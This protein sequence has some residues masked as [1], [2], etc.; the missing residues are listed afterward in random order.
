[1]QGYEVTADDTRGNFLNNFAGQFFLSNVAWALS[2]W[3][4]VTNFDLD[5][6]DWSWALCLNWLPV[7]GN[8]DQKIAPWIIS[9]SKQW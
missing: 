2:H 5:N 3:E 4:W 8:I 1:M 6:L 9:L 7:D